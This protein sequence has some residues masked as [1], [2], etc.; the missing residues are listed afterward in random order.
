MKLA[1]MIIT[2]CTATADKSRELHCG[3]LE[4]PYASVELCE[5]RIPLVLLSPEYEHLWEGDSP[6]NVI[7]IK[8]VPKCEKVVQ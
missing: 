8:E 2:L 6:V 3:D 7:A 4:I 5:S 1:L